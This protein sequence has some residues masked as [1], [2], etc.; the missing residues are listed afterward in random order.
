MSYLDEQERAIKTAPLLLAMIEQTDD[1]NRL[2]AA[3]RE[4]DGLIDA[5]FLDVLKETRE[6]WRRR[7]EPEAWPAMLNLPLAFREAIW[8]GFV[9]RKQVDL[10]LA[11]L[12]QAQDKAVKKRLKRLAFELKQEGVVPQAPKKKPS[13]FRRNFE[14]ESTLPCYVSILL[15]NNESFL[16]I[17]E[18][19]PHGM[20]SLEILE[21]EGDTIKLFHH[22]Q[23]SKKKIRTFIDD[24]IHLHKMPLYEVEPAFAYYILRRLRDRM[25]AMGHVEPAGFIH[26]L[27]Q[28]RIPAALPADHPY[29]ELLDGQ[30]ILNQLAQLQESDLLH[31]ETDFYSWILDRDSIS[32]FELGLRELEVSSLVID[33]QQRRE[34][35]EFRIDRA[36]DAFFTPARRELYAERLRDAAY[37]LARRGFMPQAQTAAAL[38]LSLLD[39]QR[40]PSA[41]PFFRNMLTK[42]LTARE[43]KPPEEK[44]GLII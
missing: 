17:N 9:A 5:D 35:I 2:F 19:L 7:E 13:F 22:D 4:Q 28:F 33:D 36:V 11:C 31:Q 8:H 3:F 23:S 27:S 6:I 41:V 14:P 20:Q 24:L 39:A 32:S 10:L 29:H 43:E 30:A 25:K 1:F 38:A 26:A 40:A 42:I 34:Q 16:I 37:L 15:P 18:T 21:R 12:E 44:S